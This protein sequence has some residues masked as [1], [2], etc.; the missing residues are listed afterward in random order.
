MPHWWLWRPHEMLLMI[1]GFV[2][3][4]IVWNNAVKMP[5]GQMWLQTWYF[6]QTVRAAMATDN[7]T[8]Q[9][10][11]Y[12]EGRRRGLSQVQI[13]TDI[14]K[15]SK[16]SKIGLSACSRLIENTPSF[17]NRSHRKNSCN[18]VHSFNGSTVPHLKFI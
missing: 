11:T 6:P 15:V 13:V 1:L 17:C 5:I 18:L 16:D 9:I 4:L 7:Y 14:F 3:V 8:H 10:D 2:V 12:L